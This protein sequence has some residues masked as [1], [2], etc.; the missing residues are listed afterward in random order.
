MSQALLL[1]LVDCDSIFDQLSFQLFDIIELFFSILSFTF[2]F[3]LSFS[4]FFSEDFYLLII[5]QHRIFKLFFTSY[6]I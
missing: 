1:N 3:I 5:L 2:L 6:Y 4:N